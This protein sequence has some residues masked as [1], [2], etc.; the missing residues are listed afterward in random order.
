MRAKTFGYGQTIP[1]DRR[2]KIAVMDFAKRFNRRHR[3]PGQ[4][5]GP[6]TRTTLEVLSVLLWTFH[7]AATGRCFPSYEA[8]ADAAECSRSSVHVAINAL[9][10]AGI[11][12]WDHRL[13]RIG[14]RVLR[15]S[16]GYRFLPPS[17]NPSGTENQKI[18]RL[19]HRRRDVCDLPGTAI[20]PVRTVAEQIAML[21]G[22]A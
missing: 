15:T 2:V 3:Q 9:E 4:H 8:I 16:N 7:N 5:R 6:L 19:K 21:N 1:G 10:D 17:G 14:R 12:T 11:L 18:I 22:G 13:K 20:S